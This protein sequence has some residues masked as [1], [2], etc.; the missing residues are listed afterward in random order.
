MQTARPTI[1]EPADEAG[2]LRALRRYMLLDSAADAD[3]DLLTE[4]AAALCGTPYAFISLV[5]Q[6]RVWYK[7]C[8]GK[9]VLQTPRQTDYCSWSVLEQTGLH[10][11]DLSRDPRTERLPLTVGPTAYRMYSGANL[12]NADG[13]ALGV[14]CVLDTRARALD[15]RQLDLLQ[16]LARQVVALM[17]LR[18]R[19][20]ELERALAALQRQ[21]LEDPLTGLRNRRA[22]M[23]ELEREVQVAQ[24]YGSPLSLVMLDLDHFKRINDGFGHAAGDAVLCGVAALLRQGLRQVD[25]AARLG[26]EEFVVLLPGTAHAGALRVAEGLRQRIAAATH[27]ADGQ[28]LQATASLGVASFGPA[29]AGAEALLGVADAA[30]Y[31]AKAA[32]R[33]QV[34]G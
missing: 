11:P 7:S 22:L 17:E 34:Q 3:F 4:L 13:H 20:L 30:L 10:I 23:T 27:L 33:N 32:G 14:L 6:D 28:A 31:R 8:H 1:P 26:G 9:Q 29:C 16:R 24:R 15:A 25:L 2:R 12:I 21:A 18:L 19:D 5:D